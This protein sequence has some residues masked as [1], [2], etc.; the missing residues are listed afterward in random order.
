MAPDAKEL[1]LRQSILEEYEAGSDVDQ[2]VKNICRKL[3]KGI[4]KSTKVQ[5]WFRRFA[6]EDK[7]LIKEAPAQQVT[8][9]EEPQVTPNEDLQV[10]PIEVPPANRPQIPNLEQI[11]LQFNDELTG[12]NMSTNDGRIG[13][14]TSKNSSSISIVDLFHDKSRKLHCRKKSKLRFHQY[15]QMKIIDDEHILVYSFESSSLVLFKVDY[16]NVNLKM[17]HKVETSNNRGGGSLALDQ[18]D[19]RK[20]I[21]CSE[22]GITFVG[23]VKNS[24]ITAGGAVRFHSRHIFFIKL[25]GQT[26]FGLRRYEN[27]WQFCEFN[28]ETSKLV[29]STRFPL[30]LG[31]DENLFALIW[32]PY[33]VW[34]GNKLYFSVESGNQLNFFSF[35]S[36]I[37]ICT[38]INI[39]LLNVTFDG[40]FLDDHEILTIK[41]SGYHFEN[42]STLY[43]F[44][45]KRP[46]SLKNLAW[47]TIVRASTLFGSPL[48]GRFAENLPYNSDLRYRLSDD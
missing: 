16:D 21:I 23:S 18:M 14:F 47:M 3:G 19:S 12:A 40:F 36:D 34:N 43:R 7:S 42:K 41:T 27:E 2:A 30:E 35:N 13:L 24:R 32:N 25:V 1:N 9:I 26:F 46:D 29:R 22:Y 48:Y 45:L 20:F 28:L 44:P 33:Y 10:I 37:G 39:V 8:P 11:V 4:V 15:D 6:N 5:W 31:E 17:L 38:R